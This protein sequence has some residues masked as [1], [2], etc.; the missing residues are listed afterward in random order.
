MPP[1]KI[2]AELVPW[3]WVCVGTNASALCDEDKCVAYR[4]G[5]V[6]DYGDVV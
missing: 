3:L 2:T 6:N 1:N 5:G 4:R